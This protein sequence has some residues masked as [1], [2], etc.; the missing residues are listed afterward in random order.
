MVGTGSQ[1]RL[2]SDPPRLSPSMNQW[3]GGIVIGLRSVQS[4]LRPA[5]A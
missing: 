2:S 5:L 4:D 1:K 3:P